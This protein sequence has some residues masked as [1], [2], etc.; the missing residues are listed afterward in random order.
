VKSA[1]QALRILRSYEPGEHVA[2]ELRRKNAVQV[3]DA[4]MPAE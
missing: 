3:L 4:A 2:L 1:S